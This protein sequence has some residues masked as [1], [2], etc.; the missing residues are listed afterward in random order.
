MKDI[1]I[2]MSEDKSP[3]NEVLS[4]LDAERPYATWSNGEDMLN[5]IYKKVESLKKEK[6]QNVLL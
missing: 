4:Y 6:E 1:N 5:K 3:L 2:K